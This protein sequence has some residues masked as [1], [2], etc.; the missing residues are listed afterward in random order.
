MEAV[1]GVEDSGEGEVHEP[2][3]GAQVEEPERPLT[4]FAESLAVRLG[5]PNSS[6]GP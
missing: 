1:G 4:Q 5:K 3:P 2:Q 6:C